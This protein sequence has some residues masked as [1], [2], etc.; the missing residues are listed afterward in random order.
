MFQIILKSAWRQL[1]KNK[2]Y[3]AINIL[4]MAVGLTMAMLS[5]LWVNYHLDFDKF[6]ANGD[7]IYQ[8]YHDFVPTGGEMQSIPALPY[9][10]AEVL[11]NPIF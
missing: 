10:M 1:W 2:T 4:G 9:P 11:R 3:S 6:H 8:A 7:D 5:A